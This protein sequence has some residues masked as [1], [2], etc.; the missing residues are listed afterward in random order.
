MNIIGCCISRAEGRT[1]RAERGKGQ[2]A[3]GKEYSKWFLRKIPPIR[4]DFYFVV[5]TNN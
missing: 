2:G 4:W 5:I 1:Q 3:K